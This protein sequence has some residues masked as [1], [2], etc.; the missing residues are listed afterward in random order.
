MLKLKK[1]LKKNPILLCLMN[2]GSSQVIARGW[3]FISPGDC[4]LPNTLAAALL[5]IAEEQ[6]LEIEL[7]VYVDLSGL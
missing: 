2:P 5:N 7:H 4:Q 6:H 3:I 1:E